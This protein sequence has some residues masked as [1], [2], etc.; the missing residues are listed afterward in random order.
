MPHHEQRMVTGTVTDIFAHRFVLETPEGRLLADLGPKGAERISLARGETVTL[1]GEMKPSE[2]KVGRFA[3][4]GGEPVAIEHGKPHDAHEPADSAAALKA[5][6]ALGYRVAAEPRRKPKHWEVLGRK[7]EGDFA[8]LH[9][10]LD[11]SLRKTKPAERE[12][13]GEAMGAGH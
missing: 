1:T 2:L 13:W 3:R 6:E 11:G 10:E 9:V 4:A 8:E 7:A 12:K 5:A